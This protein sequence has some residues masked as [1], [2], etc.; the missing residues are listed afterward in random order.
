MAAS[1]SPSTFSRKRCSRPPPCRRGRGGGRPRRRRHRGQSRGRRRRRCQRSRPPRLLELLQPAQRI[2]VLA[3]PLE[4]LALL[5]ASPSSRARARISCV[6]PRG[7]RGPRRSSRGSRPRSASRRRAPCSGRCGSRDR[8][9]PALAGNVVGAAADGVD[10]AD[11]GERAAELGD[12]GEGPEVPGP[13]RS[14]AAST[15][16][17]RG[18]SGPTPT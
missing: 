3:C 5:A 8:A 6:R 4:V 2:A 1:S 12:V 17:A 11:D 16:R 13:R 18:T 10:A 9:L 14:P 7:R 15:C